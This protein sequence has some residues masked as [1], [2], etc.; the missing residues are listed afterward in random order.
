MLLLFLLQLS[1]HRHDHKLPANILVYNIYVFHTAVTNASLA[2]TI[3]QFRFLKCHPFQLWA[4]SAS[5]VPSIVKGSWVLESVLWI[6]HFP[7][8][9]RSRDSSLA[10]C[11]NAHAEP[12]FWIAKSRSSYSV[13]TLNSGRPGGIG[14]RQEALGL[15]LIHSSWL[16]EVD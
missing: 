9:K 4:L 6:T 13:G 10:E 14:F 8:W 15:H 2:V 11:R 16:F 3:T 5:Q 1:G 12:N 7:R